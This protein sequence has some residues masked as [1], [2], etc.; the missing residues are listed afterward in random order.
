MSSTYRLRQ[1]GLILLGANAVRP[2]PGKYASVQAFFAG[3]LTAELAPQILAASVADTA[4]QVASSKRRTRWIDAA[5][6]AGAAGVL[7]YLVR[8]GSRVQSIV[9]DALVEGLGEGYDPTPNASIPIA[10]VARPFNFRDA[11]VESIRN[12]AYTQGGRRALLDIYRP[13]DVDLDRA[14]VLIQIHGGG[15]MIG[16]KQQQGLLLMNM[17]AELGWVCVS[18]NYRLAP[19]HV[20]PAQIV[21]VKKAIAWIR[22]NIATYGGDPDYLVLTGGS[23]GGH[24]SSLA[25]LTEAPQFQ[26]GFED[27]DTSV[28]GCV[29]FY[30]VYDMAGLN[31][32]KGTLM[33]RDEFLGPMIFKKDPKTHLDDFIEASPLAHVRVDAPDFFVLHGA[34]D[35]L[36]EVT[37]ARA[38][39]KALREVSTSTVTYAELPGA[40]H[41]FEI[42]SSVRS[43]YALRAVTRWLEWHRATWLAGRVV[44]RAS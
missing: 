14:P 9:E 27:A 34:N 38:F 37:Q 29:P 40:Q 26:P 19:K 4:V 43:Q 25:A 16:H 15:W 10:A 41:A 20:W 12:I 42:F 35:S 3:W 28:A 36:V 24:L 21:D 17:M 30:G 18:I 11:K 39:V 7:G 44:E 5:L 8:S 23:A 32:S 2:I 6:G 31:G 13:R 22:A 1:L 33:M